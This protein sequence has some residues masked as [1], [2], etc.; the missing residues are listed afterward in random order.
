[1][2]MLKIIVQIAVLFGFSL[3]G[4]FIHNR[5]G[6]PLP[7]SIIGLLLLVIVLSLKI[8][9][10]RWIEKG[11]GFLLAYLPLLFVPAL[12]GV[13]NYPILLSRKGAVVLFVIVISTIITMIA[14][15]KTSQML[16]QTLQK[17][18]GA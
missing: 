10:V 1:M 13:I 7:G 5:L 12:I 6:V 2:N 17:K 8:F 4:D 9:S 14:A 18:K 3:L 15:G 11:A 16:E